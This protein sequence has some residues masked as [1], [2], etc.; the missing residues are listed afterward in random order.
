MVSAS[1][2]KY[3]RIQ[4]MNKKEGVPRRRDPAAPAKK[5]RASVSTRK[6]H[7]SVAV[8]LFKG[9]FRT[10]RKPAYAVRVRGSERK[11]RESDTARGRRGWAV[12]RSL[13]AEQREE[14]SDRGGHPTF[15]C[16]TSLARIGGAAARSVGV[17]RGGGGGIGEGEGG[18]SGMG[19]EREGGSKG[20]EGGKGSGKG[21]EGRSVG[22]G[23]GRR[24]GRG[25]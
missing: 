18:G 15:F 14:G 5:A 1:P 25:G 21:K 6:N 23:G 17:D 20:Q 19:G 8:E 24:G 11:T 7:T 9:T 12:S 16:N 4:P 22:G 2:V 13:V 3:F 10:R